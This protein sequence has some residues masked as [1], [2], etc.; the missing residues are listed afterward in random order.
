M[1]ICFEGPS[2]VGKTALSKSISK[3]YPVIPEVNQLFERGDIESTYGYYEHQVERYQLCKKSQLPSLLDGDVFQPIWYNWVYQ[4]PPEFPSKEET[5][6]FYFEKIE[7]G[8]IGFPDMYFV[9]QV[10]EMELRRRKQ[11]DQTRTRRNFEKHLAYIQPQ[12]AYFTFLEK[13]TDVK[14]CFVDYTSIEET[15]KAV[16]A[17]IA[18]HSTIEIDHRIT[19]SKIIKWLAN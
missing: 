1:I 2:A 16:I 12:K 13:E 18:A 6:R 5:Q 3:E 8:K 11:S 14:V 19:Y 17:Q 7:E 15:R 9:F 10:G 4:Y